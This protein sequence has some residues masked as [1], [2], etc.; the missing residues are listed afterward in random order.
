M[1]GGLL[2]CHPSAPR[3]RLK[4]RPHLESG[5]LIV[6]PPPGIARHVPF[7][8]VAFVNETSADAS[9]SAVQ[10][11][12]AAP[13]REIRSPFVELQRN[14]SDRVGQIKRYNASLAMA[15]LGDLCHVE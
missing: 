7:A 8:R 13:D 2:N 5:V 6:S 3:H 12:V 14:I 15:G 10:I 4:F 9:R 1:M 11:F